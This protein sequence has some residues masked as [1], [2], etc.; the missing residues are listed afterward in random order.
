MQKAVR[1]DPNYAQVSRA[2]ETTQRLQQRTQV[3]RMSGLLKGTVL[4]TTGTTS[5]STQIPSVQ[6]TQFTGSGYIG[7]GVFQ[8]NY[9]VDAPVCPG[10]CHSFRRHGAR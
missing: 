3:K 1:H 6:Q 2:I 10:G 4:Q 8:R 7:K 9:S 5:M